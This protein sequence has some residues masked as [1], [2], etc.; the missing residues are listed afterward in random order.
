MGLIFLN[1]PPPPKTVKVCEYFLKMY[2]IGTSKEQT[3]EMSLQC[4]TGIVQIH[5]FEK[6]IKPVRGT[7]RL[8]RGFITCIVCCLFTVFCINTKLQMTSGH[9][10]RP[11]VDIYTYITT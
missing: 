6:Y 9:L 11:S 1:P 7:N 4:V 8:C 3:V 10:K 5:N 2:T